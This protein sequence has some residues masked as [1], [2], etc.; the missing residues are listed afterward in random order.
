MTSKTVQGL[1]ELISVLLVAAAANGYAAADPS[2]CGISNPAFCETF[3]SPQPTGNRSGDL[4]G[5]LWGVSRQ[6]GSVNFGQG[7]YYDVEPTT[8]QRCGS[9]V[10]VQPPNDVAI[11]NGMAVESVADQHG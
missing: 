9:D 6:L 1:V 7:Q 11:C 2:D 3:S 10:L 4:N 5:T 8:M